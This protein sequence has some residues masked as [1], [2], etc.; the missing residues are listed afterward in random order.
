[1]NGIAALSVIPVRREPSD[2]SEIVTQISFGEACEIT[3]SIGGWSRVCLL[4][5]GYIG[6][7]D[8]KQV[9]LID[10]DEITGDT[11]TVASDLLQLVIGEDGAIPVVIGSSL[12]FYQDKIIRL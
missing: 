7:V 10:D 8:S 12:P 11:E 5:D 3:D 4:Y 2:K 1:M 9:T 6:W